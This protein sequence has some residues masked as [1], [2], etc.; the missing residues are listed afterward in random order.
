MSVRCSSVVVIINPLDIETSAPETNLQHLAPHSHQAP[1][2]LHSTTHNT[3]YQVTE[4]Y[5]KGARQFY[6]DTVV[7]C[8]PNV[9][10][11]LVSQSFTPPDTASKL[12]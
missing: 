9:P 10:N 1:Y 5:C 4:K 11:A 3:L 2:I 7:Q 6:F 12:V 8:P